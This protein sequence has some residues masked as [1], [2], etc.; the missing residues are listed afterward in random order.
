MLYH[1]QAALE[2]SEPLSGTPEV[3]DPNSCSHGGRRA[4]VKL[5][6]ALEACLFGSGLL[7]SGGILDA[8]A[9]DDHELSSA[10][11]MASRTVGTRPSRAPTSIPPEAR[12]AC[13]LMQGLVE[14]GVRIRDLLLTLLDMR[15]DRERRRPP[16]RPLSASSGVDGP[17]RRTG[18]DV[19][20]TIQPACDFL[21]SPLTAVVRAFVE[22]L[23]ATPW[24]W[25]ATEGLDGE[26]FEGDF[27]AAVLAISAV[28]PAPL[29]AAA[30]GGGGAAGMGVSPERRIEQ[31]NVSGSQAGGASWGSRCADPTDV[32]DR[33]VA[34]AS[35]AMGHVDR[36]NVEWIDVLQ[37]VASA[38]TA[39]DSLRAYAVSCVEKSAALGGQAPFTVAHM[40]KRRFAQVRGNE[41]W[42]LLSGLLEG[43]YGLKGGALK[44][45]QA[46]TAVLIRAAAT[47]AVIASRKMRYECVPALHVCMKVFVVLVRTRR[48]VRVRVGHQERSLRDVMEMSS[49][50]RVLIT[51]HMVC[52]GR[53]STSHMPQR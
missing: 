34:G 16:G 23:A 4:S 39:A 20:A 21:R 11:A 22:W 52:R 35:M 50:L 10:S 44:G 3:M 47:T 43:A 30:G 18:A 37:R 15:Q 24:V 29:A 40:G 41:L 5:K 51:T 33:L 45:V 17:L 25:G 32:L 8:I 2:R 38:A 12:Q 53:A 6:R 27:A 9:V 42:G 28:Y 48:P 36:G 7:V 31:H 26:D 49:S 1:P 13:S 46:P 19:V 14:E